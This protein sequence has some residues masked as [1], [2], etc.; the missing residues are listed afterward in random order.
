[1]QKNGMP[2]IIVL[3]TSTWS[4]HFDPYN[5]HQTAPIF[6][7]VNFV[8]ILIIIKLWRSIYIVHAFVW[9]RFSITQQRVRINFIIHNAL[10]GHMVKYYNLYTA[11][12]QFPCGPTF[13]EHSYTGIAVHITSYLVERPLLSSF[14]EKCFFLLGRTA[15]S[16]VV[17]ASGPLHLI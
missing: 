14:S 15:Q 12:W 9:L 5:T 13:Q 16:A 1:M 8:L 4:L 6:F 3:F 11:A 7:L 10:D 2:F 17:L